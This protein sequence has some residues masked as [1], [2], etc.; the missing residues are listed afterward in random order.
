MYILFKVDPEINYINVC[1]FVCF[2]SENSIGQSADIYILSFMYLY[3]R[4][5]YNKV[6]IYIL[7]CAVY[8]E[9]AH[10]IN[11][12][13]A[14]ASATTLSCCGFA[15]FENQ[16]CCH[17]HAFDLPPVP[18][19]DPWLYPHHLVDGRTSTVITPSAV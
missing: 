1:Y 15:L 3:I 9:L 2:L 17:C 4:K 16:L 19:L 8:I 10:F 7:V 11:C 5:V 6:Y 13:G 18:R 12:R 14:A